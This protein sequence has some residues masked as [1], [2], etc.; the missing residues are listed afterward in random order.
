MSNDTTPS[1]NAEGSVIHDIGFRHY[2]GPRL[3]RG[4]AFRSLMIETLRGAYGLGR[5]PKVKAMPWI[6]TGIM[7]LVALILVAI[8]I[9]TKAP[10]PLL[11]YTQLAISEWLLVALFVA[12]RAPYAISRD[13]RDGVM[14]LYLSRPIVR[15]DYALAKFLG[16]TSAVFLFIAGPL[17]LM[18]A[19]SLLAKMPPWHE[20]WTWLGA[21]LMAALLSI[22]LTAIS[23]A[24][25]AYT[26]RRGFGVAAIMASL[27]LA[28][29]FTSILI[30]VM[31]IQGH[32]A[33]GAYFAILNP[34]LLIDGLGASW[35]GV[36]SF[37]QD[38]R[39]EGLGGGTIFTLAL[40]AIVAAALGI[41]MRRL[42]K[43]GSA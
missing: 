38:V 10:E 33:G 25:A 4:W 11:P 3:G 1:V 20:I 35:L 13:M 2:D 31:S 39:P 32:A 24:F 26:R 43:E 37:L 34:F 14:P 30:N 28:F 36:T 17:V 19:G 7:A 5:P 41:L 29:G 15:S 8:T 9:V 12:G 21:L 22:V 42:R 18:L 40:V 23:M 16:L 6:L 27:V